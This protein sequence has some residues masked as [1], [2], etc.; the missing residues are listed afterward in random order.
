VGCQK[1]DE[2]RSI[3]A[4]ALR[5]AREITGTCVALERVM[6]IPRHLALLSIWLAIA[7][8]FAA[9]GKTCTSGTDLVCNSSGMGS[10]TGPSRL[11]DTPCGI[12]TT[13][14]FLQFNFSPLCSADTYWSVNV[15]LPA[16][17]GPAIYSLPS[18]EVVIDA[19][20]AFRTEYQS[21]A[22]SNGQ[23]PLL[24]VTGGMVNVI[25]ASNSSGEVAVD[26]AFEDSLNET[27]A[28]VG[29]VTYTNCVLE[30]GLSCPD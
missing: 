12:V 28:L 5:F 23:P 20:F 6:L 13:A 29:H 22:G 30:T 2:A 15:H 14:T 10:V 11:T 17:D 7:T 26:I 18:P 1:T 24:R 21:T 25:D 16:K 8:T 19:R 27:I 9:C 4:P 3:S